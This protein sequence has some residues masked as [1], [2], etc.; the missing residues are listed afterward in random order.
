MGRGKTIVIGGSG[1]SGTT[2]LRRCFDN[3]PDLWTCPRGEVQFFGA[4]R[5]TLGLLGMQYESNDGLVD[6]ELLA[7]TCQHLLKRLTENSG[8][9]LLERHGVSSLKKSVEAFA[10]SIRGREV[11]PSKIWDHIGRWMWGLF[12]PSNCKKMWLQKTPWDCHYF[13]KLDRCFPNSKFIHIIRDPR[14]VIDSAM[15]KRWGGRTIVH[16][17]GWYRLW[18]ERWQQAE[19]RGV[20]RMSNYHEVRYEQLVRDPQ[21]WRRLLKFLAIKPV[22]R[23]PLRPVHQ[24]RHKKWNDSQ[25]RE[26]RRLLTIYPWLSRWHAGR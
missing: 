20:T 16:A 14:D 7:G 5:Y 26:Y 2:V 25:R 11:E 4:T 15:A 12:V 1:R 24:G 23:P 13:D 9:E 10:S 19:L 21:V 22:P 3:H 17:I 18:A 8:R 6:P